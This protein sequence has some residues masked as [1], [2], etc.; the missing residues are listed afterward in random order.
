V[1]QAWAGNNRDLYAIGADGHGRERLTSGD[2][3]WF[4]SWSPDGT[5]IAF[6]DNSR[7]GVSVIRRTAND[8]SRPAL[9]ADGLQVPIFSPD[10]RELLLVGGPVVTGEVRIVPAD[11]GAA[12]VLFNGAL[13]GGTALA[14]TGRWSPTGDR[15]Y[16]FA[17]DQQG[18]SSIWS[19]PSQG[20]TPAL[21]IRFD[22]P[23]RES[24]RREFDT[25]GRHFY[26]TLARKQ[27]DVWVMDVE[28]A[29]K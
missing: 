4:P 10:G 18:R 27:G 11:G 2:H 1:F 7:N 12:R 20:G 24:N 6:I 19:M 16:L 13:P 22:D 28:R 3:E 29:R 21:V 14:S 5:R 23:S 8:W 15:V 17:V 25:D 26:L 9:V